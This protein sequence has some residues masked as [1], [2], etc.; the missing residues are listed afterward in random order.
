VSVHQSVD[1]CRYSTSVFL[2]N[3]LANCVLTA[4]K[5]SAVH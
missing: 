1:K 4:E 5:S 3:N 2:G